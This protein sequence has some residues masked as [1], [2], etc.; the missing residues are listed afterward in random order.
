MISYQLIN[1]SIYV[2][3]YFFNIELQIWIKKLYAAIF[4]AIN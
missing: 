3:S 4:Q 1:S 2:Y